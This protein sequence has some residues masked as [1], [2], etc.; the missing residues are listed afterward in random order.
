M[1][2]NTIVVN[3]I[4]ERADK[5]VDLLA[6]RRKESDFL[7][8]SRSMEPLAPHHLPPEAK[9]S[10]A[11]AIE[12]ALENP[13]VILTIESLAAARNVDKAVVRNEAYE[14]LEEMASKAHLP[15][16]RWIGE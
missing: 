2:N 7:W 5:F 15:T 9:Y 8:V 14:M 12:A 11:Q 16:V 6:D 13:R 1:R 3:K 4:M 10:R